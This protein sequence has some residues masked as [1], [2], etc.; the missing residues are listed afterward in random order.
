MD[1][2]EITS[3]GG[4]YPMQRCVVTSNKKSALNMTMCSANKWFLEFNLNLFQN[5]TVFFQDQKKM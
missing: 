4:Q 3:K 5:F 2:V 1:Q